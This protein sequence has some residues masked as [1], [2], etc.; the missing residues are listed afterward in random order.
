MSALDSILS[1]PPTAELEPLAEGKLVQTDEEDMGM[2]YDEL[3]QYG[4]LRNMSCNFRLGL[5][6]CLDMENHEYCNSLC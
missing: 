2:S 4:R 5:D 6:T 3:S 1:A